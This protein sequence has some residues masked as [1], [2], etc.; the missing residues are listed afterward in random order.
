MVLFVSLQG[1]RF[2]FVKILDNKNLKRIS[3][4]VEMCCTFVNINFS[5]MCKTII[6]RCRL[7]NS[8]QVH[9]INVPSLET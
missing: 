4:K 5:V 1:E 9:R 8:I 3:H 2:S 6:T 7:K